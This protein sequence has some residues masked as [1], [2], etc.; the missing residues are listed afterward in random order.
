MQPAD[1]SGADSQIFGQFV[2]QC[3]GDGVPGPTPQDDAGP[4]I[5]QL[6][7]TFLTGSGTPSKDS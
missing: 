7:K 1:N 2:K 4:Q 5:I 6:Y 3:E